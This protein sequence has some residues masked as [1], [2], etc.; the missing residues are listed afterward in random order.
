[1]A[2]QIMAWSLT[3][4]QPQSIQIFCVVVVVVPSSN[5]QCARCTGLSW[6]LL[7]N[8]LISINC[9]PFVYV[10]NLDLVG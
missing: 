3:R 8:E 9:K 10:H 6:V 5:L 2:R 4:T 7:G 1:M